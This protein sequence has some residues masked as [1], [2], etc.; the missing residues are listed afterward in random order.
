MHSVGELGERID[1]RRLGLRHEQHV[2]L[3]DRL[4]A[5]DARAVEA[6]AVL[7]DILVQL[8]DG[9]GEVLPQ[10]RKVHEPQVDRLDVLFAAQ[11]Q[12]FLRRHTNVPLAR[13]G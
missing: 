3:V 8:V 1:E 7:E 4:P 10:A 6:E 2:A 9:N 12:N 5:A 13:R 11:G